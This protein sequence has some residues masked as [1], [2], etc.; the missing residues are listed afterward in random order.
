MRGASVK[1]FLTAAFI[2]PYCGPCTSKLS[3][4]ETLANDIAIKIIKSLNLSMQQY[5]II[6]WTKFIF[7]CM[8][9]CIIYWQH[10]N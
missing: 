3:A 7:D 8:N 10:N 4:K 6:N 9:Y 2:E 5:D 1:E